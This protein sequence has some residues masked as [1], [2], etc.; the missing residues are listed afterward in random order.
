MNSAIQMKQLFDNNIRICIF[1]NLKITIIFILVAV[2]ISGNSQS[3][4][5][6]LKET[7]NVNFTFTTIQSYSTGIAANNAMT[8]R[9]DAIGSNW[10]LYVGA[11]TAV[12]D[13]WNQV[14]S[15]SSY[16]TIPG[17]EILEMR[18]RNT[19]STSLIPGYFPITDINSPTYIIGSENPADPSINCSSPGTNTPGNYLG[20][21]ACYKFNVDL[22][23]TPGF[24]L[25]PGL[26]NLHIKYVIIQDL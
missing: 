12:M 25:Q 20:T 26:Y 2:G 11:E 23:I 22:R 21:P 9:I 14:L 8:L 17:I 10:D 4:S 13:K 15:Y 6:E 24:T 7:P 18:F 1:H 19:G 16:G 5:F 3:V